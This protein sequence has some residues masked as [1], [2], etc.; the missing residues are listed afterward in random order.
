MSIETC[1]ARAIQ[2]DLDIVEALPEIHDLPMEQLEGF[3][4]QYVCGIQEKL[5]TIIQEQGE[6]Y[7]RSK[8]AA[9]LCA[10]CLN[11]GLTIPPRML[12][13]MCQTIVQLVQMRA[14]LVLDTP[15]GSSLYY[16]KTLVTV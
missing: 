1:I 10:M 11:F 9:G 16:I 14:E 8:D 6:P 12:L 2:N 5:S 15:E 4:E 3:V 13:R 7:L